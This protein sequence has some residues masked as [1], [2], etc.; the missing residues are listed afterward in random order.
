MIYNKYIKNPYIFLRNIILGG[1]PKTKDKM[2]HP[3]WYN[4]DISREF[5][6]LEQLD[7]MWY[8]VKNV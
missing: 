7:I 5:K 2:I 3:I 4:I 6:D 8:I 1:F